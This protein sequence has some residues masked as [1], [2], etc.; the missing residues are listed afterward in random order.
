MNNKSF[1]I[2]VFLNF[3]FVK[4]SFWPEW[5]SC[6]LEDRMLGCWF[7]CLFLMLWLKTHTWSM[8]KLYEC[9]TELKSYYEFKKK[10]PCLSSLSC[11]FSNWKKIFLILFCSPCAT[12]NYHLSLSIFFITFLHLTIS[13]VS[14]CNCI[15]TVYA[16]YPH[17]YVWRKPFKTIKHAVMKASGQCGIPTNFI[18]FRKCIHWVA[19]RFITDPS[20]LLSQFQF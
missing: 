12:C 15:F 11:Y 1:I 5:E 13:L 7:I 16:S 19:T 20:L 10:A 14:V 4:S 6:E 8:K 9:W 17:L 18:C 3:E 2:H